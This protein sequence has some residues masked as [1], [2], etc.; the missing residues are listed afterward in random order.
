MA[1]SDSCSLF[2]VFASDAAGECLDKIAKFAS[3][4]Q[5]ET[6][7]Y[8]KP[9]WNYGPEIHVLMQAATELSTGPLDVDLCILALKFAQRFVLFQTLAGRQE[10]DYQRYHTEMRHYA[11][12]IQSYLDAEPLNERS[13]HENW[14][15]NSVRPFHH[16]WAARVAAEKLNNPVLIFYIDEAITHVVNGAPSSSRYRTTG[17]VRRSL[18]SASF[19]QAPTS[20]R[21][22]RSDNR[23]NAALLK[24]LLQR[25]RKAGWPAHQ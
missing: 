18:W 2:G 14:S 11:E 9:P 22:A 15:P 3:T 6:E 25:L 5:E 10:M 20:R 12:V 17:T 23:R 7:H 19:P 4:L 16:L 24:H 13:D 21:T 8:S 1:L